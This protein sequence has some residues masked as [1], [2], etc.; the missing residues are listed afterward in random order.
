MQVQSL[1]EEPRSYMPHGQ[2]KKNW[3]KRSNNAMLTA[4]GTSLHNGKMA[5][6]TMAM[7]RESYGKA[8]HCAGE[9]LSYKHI[10]IFQLTWPNYD[11]AA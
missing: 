9:A 3:Q 1:V 2:K 10:A 11:E 6:I 5:L 8:V 4:Y 7:A